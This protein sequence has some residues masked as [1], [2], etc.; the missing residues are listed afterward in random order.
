MLPSAQTPVWT[1]PSLT[2]TTCTVCGCSAAAPSNSVLSNPIIEYT[3]PCKM[4]HWGGGGGGGGS[5]G[6]LGSIADICVRA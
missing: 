5:T 2:E 4:V 1:Y 3:V 6:D